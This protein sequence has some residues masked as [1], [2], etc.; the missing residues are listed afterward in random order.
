MNAIQIIDDNGA[1][2]IQINVDLYDHQETY[3]EGYDG[4]EDNS[5]FIHN[6]DLETINKRCS[7][8][9]ADL[10]E[11]PALLVNLYHG[12]YYIYVADGKL[13]NFTC[14]PEV[15]S[16]PWRIIIKEVLENICSDN[17]DIWK[18]TE[19]P[20]FFT[21]FRAMIQLIWNQPA[22]RKMALDCYCEI[23]G[24]TRVRYDGINPPKY[25][26]YVLCR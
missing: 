22:F 23:T 21:E 2:T 17:P 25:K 16:S 13:H 15:D 26:Y 24:W 11:A 10:S 19:L 18:V 5:I 20:P 12:E 7:R 4:Y 3:G 1:C 8:F 14:T 9:V 6:Y